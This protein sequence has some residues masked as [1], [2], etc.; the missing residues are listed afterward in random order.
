MQVVFLGSLKEAGMSPTLFLSAVSQRFPNMQR[1][2][3]YHHVQQ[4]EMKEIPTLEP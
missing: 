4:F 3:L 1:H 2:N